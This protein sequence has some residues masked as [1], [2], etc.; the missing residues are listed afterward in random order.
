MK[1]RLLIFS[2]SFLAT[3]WI[4]AEDNWPRF[5]GPHGTG[6]SEA[7]EV[8]VTWNADSVAWKVELKG[9]GQSSPVI[10]DDKIFLTSATV[11]GRERLI[12]CLDRRNGELIWEAK[13]A[14]EQL[15]TP[16]RMNSWATPTCVTDGE[17]V[18][19]FFG[20]GGI[21]CYDLD[22]KKQWSKAVGDFPGPWGIAASPIIY[23]DTVIQNCDAEGA[24]FLI[25]FNK[26]TGEEVWKTR[27]QDMPRGGW[28]TPIVIEFGGR[29]ELVLNG[30]FG[31][32]SYDPRTGEDLWFCAGFNGRGTPVPD[33]ADGKLF[34]VNGKP[35]NT[36][37]VRPGG[38]GDVTATHR[39]WNSRRQGGRDLPSPAVIG[40]YVLISSMS[41]ILT[42]YDAKT[43]D[44]HYSE[45]LGG[46]FAAS[47]LVA[48][49]MAYFTSTMGETIVIR[50]GKSL[51]VVAR[52]SLG[53]SS[54][55]IFR[56]TLAPVRGQLFCRS[57]SVLYC[58]GD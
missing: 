13:V 4:Q 18:V 34:V 50:P 25:A 54:S 11:D 5:R 49:G 15:E 45:R 30:E 17:F 38:N 26:K 37:S 8:P 2:F 19:A 31:V 57:Q 16:H 3:F 23:G 27:R 32:N 56:A 39:V 6:H 35:G 22:G 10:W 41:G 51:D 21:H 53:S 12:L 9:E 28:S 52:N 48:N 43:G 40:D 33:Y 36:Y 20:P 55:E 14:V 47:P 1:Y 46:E 24:S 42:C 29:E 44:A 7:K 58:I